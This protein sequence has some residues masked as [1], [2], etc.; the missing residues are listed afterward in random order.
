MSRL[1]L[2][3]F[4]SEEAETREREENSHVR[5]GRPQRDSEDADPGKQSTAPAEK[6]VSA[7]GSPRFVPVGFQVEHLRLLDEAVMKLRHAGHWKASKSGIIR[8]LIERHAA[9]LDAV[10][11]GD[12]V[13]RP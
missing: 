11:L 8:K 13:R 10:W 12:G 3:I 2:D 6:D 5:T 1:N 4:G 7:N 9:D